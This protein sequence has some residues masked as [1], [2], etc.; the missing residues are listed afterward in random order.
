MNR[1][2][3]FIFVRC[4]WADNMTQYFLCRRKDHIANSGYTSGSFMQ[5]T[6]MLF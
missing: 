2:A 4:V 6:G 5:G 1:W 3:A